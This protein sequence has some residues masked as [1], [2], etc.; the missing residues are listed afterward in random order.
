MINRQIYPS[1]LAEAIIWKLIKWATNL[2]R[3]VP[4]N[5]LEGC[6]GLYPQSVHI[7]MNWHANISKYSL[8]STCCSHKT[9]PTQTPTPIPSQQG[10]MNS[11]IVPSSQWILALLTMLSAH[12][13]PIIKV[14][15]KETNWISAGICNWKLASNDASR[16][17]CER[18]LD[19]NQASLC[20]LWQIGLCCALRYQHDQGHWIFLC[21]Q[22]CLFQ[23]QSQCDLE[24]SKIRCRFSNFC[25]MF[26][27]FVLSDSLF[28]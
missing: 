25:L 3:N 16:P 14:S 23:F 28:L 1:P 2:H 17:C 27:G 4:T 21:P 11:D 13:D 24:G 22:S 9:T 5:V 19:I 10:D 20:L 26:T 6:L 15:S 8:F 7:I 18:S 12:L